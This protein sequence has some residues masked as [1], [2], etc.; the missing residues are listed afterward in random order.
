MGLLRKDL[1]DRIGRHLFTAFTWVRRQY[2]SVWALIAAVVVA[3]QFSE[4]IL[5]NPDQYIMLAATAPDANTQ[6]TEFYNAFSS[7]FADRNST[8]EVRRFPASDH[9][10]EDLANKCV[11]EPDCLMFIGNSTS[12]RTSK[13]LDV[14]LEHDSNDRPIFVMP[15]ATATDLTRRARSS[16][17]LSVLR[18]VP[19]NDNQAAI[20]TRVLSDLDRS[21]DGPGVIIYIDEDNPEYSTGLARA[22]AREVRESA[23]GHVLAEEH[24]G[25]SNSVVHT[26]VMWEHRAQSSLDAIVYVGTAHHCLL[27]IDQM[28]QLG[29]KVPVVFTDG[30]SLDDFSARTAHLEGGAYRLSATSNY[31]EIGELTAFLVDSILDR[32]RGC[33]RGALA[34]EVAEN[35]TTYRPIAEAHRLGTNT[36]YRF[37]HCGNNVEVD[38]V[39]SPASVVSDE[40]ARAEM[41]VVRRNRDCDSPATLEETVTAHLATPRPAG[42][43]ARR[44]RLGG[45]VR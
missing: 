21:S 5:P 12:T 28:V 11:S 42:T 20:V 27:L 45:W 32:C 17:Y 26:L 1:K 15:F 29:S 37:D 40:E 8:V 33:K 30:C 16:N 14:F 13:T 25:P 4:L 3:V 18:I 41:L 19:D 6:P 43:P 34:R 10:I 36:D 24:I 39:V 35:R 38:F 2:R 44:A 23:E 31:G 22:V 9:N 7:R